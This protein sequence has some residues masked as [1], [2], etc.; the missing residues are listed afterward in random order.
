MN[1]LIYDQ[2]GKKQALLQNVTS[3]QWK[4]RYWESGS[5]EIHARP[6]DE[7][8]RYLVEHNRVVCQERMRSCSLTTCREATR[9]QTGMT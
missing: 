2:N 6:T 7:N 1:Y 9:T 8:V 5:A 3:I 4:P